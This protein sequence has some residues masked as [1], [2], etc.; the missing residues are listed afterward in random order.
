MNETWDKVI[1]WLGVE[2][3]KIGEKKQWGSLHITFQ[4]GEARAI[5]K[6]LSI[7]VAALKK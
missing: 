5:K 2:A 6:E 1:E 4:N 7:E 3:G